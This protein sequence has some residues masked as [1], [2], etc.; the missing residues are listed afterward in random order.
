LKSNTQDWAQI[1]QWRKAKRAELIARRS[2]FEPEERRRWNEMMT[3]RLV[4]GFPE[5]AGKT[6][7]FCWPYKAEFDARFAIRQ[8]RE[9]GASA[10]LPAVVERKRPLEFRLWWPGAATES[11]VYGI[12]VPVKTEVV[13]PDAAIVPMNGFDEQGYRLG[14]GAATLIAR[15]LRLIPDLWQ[16]E[17]RSRRCGCRPSILNRMTS[18]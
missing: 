2:G 6:I 11:G 15:W 7:G 18:Q 3:E 16:S 14:Y 9:R 17:S 1:S 13:I 12:P 10:A 5:L 8:F 4:R